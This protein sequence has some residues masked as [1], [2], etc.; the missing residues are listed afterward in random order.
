MLPCIQ[1]GVKTYM[2]ETE[3]E[4]KGFYHYLAD[5][6]SKIG[7]DENGRIYSYRDVSEPGISP[8]LYTSGRRYG[9]HPD[10]LDLDQN[11]IDIVGNTC[12]P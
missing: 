11:S 1:Q 5:I 7:I 3:E 10:D 8:Y 2:C 12:N 9:L 4:K 6:S